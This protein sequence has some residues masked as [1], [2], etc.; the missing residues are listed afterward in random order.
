MQR[1]DQ[2]IKFVDE[3]KDL[4]PETDTEESAEISDD[5]LLYLATA[6][7]KGSLLDKRMNIA[8]QI[9]ASE[10]V[11]MLME[12]HRSPQLL[13]LSGDIHKASKSHMQNRDAV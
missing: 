3:L 12:K 1:Y 4:N 9:K 8:H 2:I 7:H 5:T 11:E 10:L 13:Q 6:Y